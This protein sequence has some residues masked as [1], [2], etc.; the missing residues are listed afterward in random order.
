MILSLTHSHTCTHTHTQT[1][2]QCTEDSRLC[3][4]LPWAVLIIKI[5]SAT[6]PSQA[7]NKPTSPCL[8]RV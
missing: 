6:F 7:N 3:L 1:K 4:S 8:I 5:T 2:A